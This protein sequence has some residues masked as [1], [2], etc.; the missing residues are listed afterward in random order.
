MAW[1]CG[2]VDGQWKLDWKRDAHMG[3]GPMQSLWELKRL[4]KVGCVNAHHKRV[5]GITK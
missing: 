2:Q 1:L 3:H 4:I 5:T